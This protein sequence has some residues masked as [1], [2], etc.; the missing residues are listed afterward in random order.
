MGIMLKNY[1]NNAQLVVVVLFAQ[2]CLTLHNPMDCSPA[3][4][5]LPGD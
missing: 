1:K 5:P 3:K 4:A 2:S